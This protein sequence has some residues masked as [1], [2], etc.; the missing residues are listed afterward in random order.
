MQLL[1]LSH[2]TRMILTPKK[3]L[4]SKNNQSSTLKHLTWPVTNEL[5]KNEIPK[6]QSIIATINA[7]KLACIGPKRQ[8]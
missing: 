6:G 7:F 3:I 2:N 8:V 4:A 5:E 1:A